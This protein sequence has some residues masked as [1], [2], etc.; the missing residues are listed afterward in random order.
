MA[1]RVWVKEIN[2]DQGNRP[3][4]IIRRD[5]GLVVWWRRARIVLWS[6]QGMDV[7]QI[8]KIAFTSKDRVRSQS[9]G[10][11]ESAQA[12]A[13]GLEHRTAAT[14]PRLRSTS[15]GRWRLDSN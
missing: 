4:R 10:R 9:T 14:S 1:E 6:A 15:A 7:P 12:G 13:S 8:A 2:N 11:F 5:S 3:L